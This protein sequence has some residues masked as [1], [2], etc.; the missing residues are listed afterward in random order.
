MYIALLKRGKKVIKKQPLVIHGLS[1]VGKTYCV[2]NFAQENFEKVF[3]FNCKTEKKLLKLF[4]RSLEPTVLIDKLNKYTQDFIDDENSILIFDDLDGVD[5]IIQALRHFYDDRPKLCI[6]AIVKD[7]S[8]RCFN[9][10]L[11]SLDKVQTLKLYPLTFI[12]FLYSIGQES[13]T[14]Y[15]K[16]IKKIKSL[17]NYMCKILND[18]LSI[19][20]LT[21]GMPSAICAFLDGGVESLCA[22]KENFLDYFCNSLK[23]RCTVYQASKISHVLT[24]A[25]KVL[26]SDNKKFVYIIMSPDGKN[27]VHDSTLKLLQESSILNKVVLNTA[28]SY[29]LRGNNKESSFALCFADVGLLSSIYGVKSTDDIFSQKSYA[30]TYNFIYQSLSVFF[31]PLR[32]YYSNSPVGSIDFIINKGDD[33]IPCCIDLKGDKDP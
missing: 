22:T 25:S 4:A 10:T 8:P 11:C 23:E 24:S 17:D 7:L 6:I 28:P 21:G 2:K 33:I 31:S 15:L 12:E 30:L 27:R 32:F 3:Y 9:K 5:K 18:Y 20:F 1:G 19:Y 13:L 14:T 29:P 16:D 26:D